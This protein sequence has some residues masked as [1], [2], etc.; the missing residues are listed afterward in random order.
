MNRCPSCAKVGHTSIAAIEAD[1]CISATNQYYAIAWSTYNGDLALEEV[2]AY[3]REID[4]KDN[5]NY[6]AILCMYDLVK[7]GKG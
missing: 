4:D 2:E 5:T 7:Y 6:R 1:E 3:L